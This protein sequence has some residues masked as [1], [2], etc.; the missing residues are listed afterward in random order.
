MDEDTA[1][2]VSAFCPGC[3]STT[4]VEL[5][6]SANWGNVVGMC[7]PADHEFNYT[8]IDHAGILREARRGF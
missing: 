5:L 2:V 4:D 1:T 7:L 3:K 6:D 8:P